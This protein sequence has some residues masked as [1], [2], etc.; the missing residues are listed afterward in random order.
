MASSSPAAASA[1]DNDSKS[2]LDDKAVIEAMNKAWVSTNT[3]SVTYWLSFPT[4][5]KAF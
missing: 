2:K 1:P 5:I 3:E 4:H